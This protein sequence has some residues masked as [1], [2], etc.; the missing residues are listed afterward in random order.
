MPDGFE[1]FLLNGLLHQRYFQQIYPAYLL[2]TRWV[3]R[4]LTWKRHFLENSDAA[5]A[6]GGTQESNSP[7]KD[8]LIDA[9]YAQIGRLKVEND[10]LKKK[11][12]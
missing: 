7:D 6:R 4:W 11:L 8:K 9:L 3:G 1:H 2:K 12:K 10:F 5:F